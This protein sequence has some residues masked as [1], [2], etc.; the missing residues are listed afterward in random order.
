[1]L[2]KTGIRRSTRL[3]IIFDSHIGCAEGL[4]LLNFE[5]GCKCRSCRPFFND[6]NSRSCSAALE[7]RTAVSFA[8]YFCL[9]FD[10][11]FEMKSA[12]AEKKSTVSSILLCALR[13]S[14]ADTSKQKKSYILRKNHLSIPQTTALAIMPTIYGI[15]GSYTATIPSKIHF[16]QSML[17]S[18]YI[19]FSPPSRM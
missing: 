9:L 10:L 11:R 5:F 2:K 16:V 14:L 8:C 15:K 7:Q 4:R 13:C 6:E 1:M 12:A 17:S 3:R 18:P 19:Y